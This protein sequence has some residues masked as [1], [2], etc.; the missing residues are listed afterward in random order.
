MQWGGWKAGL[1]VAAALALTAARRV[2]RSAAWSLES[3]AGEVLANFFALGATIVGA[4]VL[5]R[6]IQLRALKVA[7]DD[8]R[9]DI[10]VDTVIVVGAAVVLV[11]SLLVL[12][13]HAGGGNTVPLPGS[14][15]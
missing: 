4:A 2:E 5:L 11:G 8:W 10:G 15:G 3:I 14:P 6:W 1:M 13:G 9:R 7:P 12:V